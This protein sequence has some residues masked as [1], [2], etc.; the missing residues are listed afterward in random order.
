MPTRLCDD[1]GITQIPPSRQH[2]KIRLTD[3]AETCDRIAASLGKS[4][5]TT[6]IPYSTILI[7]AA[8][9]VY[10][11]HVAF[12]VTGNLLGNVRIVQLE[13]YG[14]ITFAHLGNYELWRLFASQLIHAK[15]I[16]ML[17]NVL[18]LALLGA[19]LERYIR[20]VRFFLLWLVAGSAGTLVSTLFATP[21]WNLGTG[22]SQAVLGIAAFGLVLSLK[23][24]NSSKW[25]VAVL[26]FSFIPA[27]ALDF[28]YAGYPKPGHVA[29]ALLGAIAGVIYCKKANK[30]PQHAPAAP[31]SL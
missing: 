1:P 22:A 10:S 2:L 3:Q 9:L 23:G 26:C 28:I 8:T 15:Q 18:S 14:G 12:D 25:L 5:K 19:F 7:C 6:Y 13:P 16:H 21:P 30:A 24:V 4:M 27:F 29:S 17:Y 31:E 11:M 20:A